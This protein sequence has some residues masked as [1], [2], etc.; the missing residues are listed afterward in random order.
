MSNNRIPF[1]RS[2]RLGLDI[3]RHIALDAGAGTGKTTVMA[4]R[5]VQHLISPLQRSTLVLPN[6]P[7]EP[8]SGHGSLR[9]PARERTERKAWQGLLPSEVVAITFTRKAASEL[10]ARIRARVAATRKSPVKAGDDEGIFD[11]RISSDADVEMLLS[12]LDEAP[13]STIDAFLSQLLAPHLDLVAVHPSREQ[14]AQERAPLLIEEALHSAWRIRTVNDAQEAGV[15]GYVNSFIEA[16]N[17]LA[18]A[19][20]GQE[21]AS[22]VLSG[23]LNK[24]LFVEESKRAIEAHSLRLGAPFGHDTQIPEQLFLEMF[25]QPIAEEIDSFAVE[26][27]ALLNDYIDL[28]LPH[29]ASYIDPAQVAAG[30]PETRFN[31]LRHMARH[32][33]E[34]EPLLRMQ[35]VWNT[36]IA[37]GGKIKTDG[38]KTTFFPKGA[39][40]PTSTSG[41]HPG[42]LP[43]SKAKGVTGAQKDA[44]N[45]SAKALGQTMSNMLNSQTG[46]LICLMGRSATL[47][48]PAIE[49]PYIPE[50]ST[51]SLAELGV[52]LPETMGDVGNMR[53]GAALQSQILL[54][55]LRVHEACKDIL[56]QLK[57]HEGVHDFDDIQNLA[58]DLLLARCPDMVRFDYPVAVVEALD[59]LGNE[60]WS[61]HHISRALTLAG[62]DEAC[63]LDLQRRHHVL[64][65]IRRQYRAFIIDEYQDTN[66]AHFRLL[67]RLW[68]HRSLHHGEPERPLGPWD[69]TVCIVGDMKQSIYRF[70]QAE[71]SVMRRAVAAIMAANENELYESRWP[72]EVRREG[73]GRD[74]RPLG[75]GGETSAFITADALAPGEVVSQAWTHVS[76]GTDT[77][78][79]APEFSGGDRQMFR[80]HGLIDLTSNYRT[81]PNLVHAMNGI[82]RDVFHPRH[83]L[84]PGEWHA[85]AQ[86]L[87]AG[88]LS[89]DTPGVLEWLM[90]L[91]TEEGE[92]S[93]DLSVPVDVFSNQKSK[94]IHLEHELIAGRLSALLQGQ[95]TQVWSAADRAFRDVEGQDAAVDPSD[96]MILV[97]SRK[98]VPDLIR[99][100][101]Q[102]GIPVVA[103]R[104]GSLLGRP[105]VQPLMAL[106]NLIANP[107]SRAA[108]LGIARSPVLGFTDG[109]IQS[110]MEQAPESDWWS[111]LEHHAPN[112][113]IATLVAHLGRL[114]RKGALY[115]VVDAVLDHSDLL[116]AFPEDT[117]RQNAEAWYSLAASI[118]NELGHEAA[119]IHER[120]CELQRLGQKGPSATNVPAGGAVRIMT[121]HNAKGLEAD[122]VFVAGLFK[123]GASDTQL[124]T[125]ENVLV[126]PQII[127]GRINPWRSLTR[128]QDGLWEFTLQLDQAQTQAERRR[129]FYVALTRARDRL[130]LVGAHKNTST[131]NAASGELEVESKASRKTMGGMWIEGLRSLAHEGQIADSPWL[132][133]GD[134][135]HQI[136]PPYDKTTLTLDPFALSQN[137]KLG[138]EAIQSIRIYHHPD[139]FE[140]GQKSTPLE[141]WRLLEQRIEDLP[142]ESQPQTPPL[143]VMESVRMTAHGLDTSNLC[144][145]RHWLSEVKGWVPEKLNLIGVKKESK[146]T[147]S[148]Y[149]PA[150]VFGTMM[151][152]LVEL[153]LANPSLRAAPHSIPLPAAWQ[154]EG[155]DGLDDEA[156]ID[157]VLAEEGYI[158]QGKDASSHVAKRAGERLVELGSLVREGLLG[159]LAAGETH[160]GLTVEGLRTELPFY[161]SHSVDVEG[162]KRTMFD[163]AEPI[164]HATIEALTLIFD[165][166]ADLVLALR[167]DSNQGF[168]QI[169]DLKTKGCRNGFNATNISKGTA[170]QQYKGDV[171]NPEP[172]TDAERALLEEHR[173]QL[174][175]YSMALEAIEMSK[176][177]EEQ[178]TILPPAL[179]VGASGRM[180][181]LSP[182]AFVKARKDLDDQLEWIGH[183]A[184]V[185]ETLDE[186]ERLGPETSEPCLTCPFYTGDV[187]LCGPAGSSLGL[188]PF[189][190]E[191]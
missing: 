51:Y 150:T 113:N 10:K 112:K 161:H 35:W 119:A 13:I 122:V 44:I 17:R 160:F 106:L 164:N 3:D 12:S 36:A 95:T 172:S 99:R 81:K 141:D 165:G 53:V 26:L 63:A 1:N 98:H 58:A 48:S 47:L 131:I 142:V 74:P 187:R 84:L 64:Q 147:S 24:S 177:A 169:V 118:G 130:I 72:P 89:D 126:T 60:P 69:P 70:R 14:I 59:G 4:E 34:Q 176:P 92:V 190:A 100:L 124:N 181:Q 138:G 83:H 46:R 68:G 111:H 55:L 167:N 175:L 41:W 184:V 170:L 110:M 109:Q 73:F 43:K 22:V 76:L 29:A 101:Q 137:A 183:L 28:Y 62:D 166:R 8:L 82:F 157:V 151:H 140:A 94:D 57:A 188:G 139:C 86:D 186:P 79:Y 56:A 145:R 16:R 54:D 155:K 132:L 115:E 174:T 39:L 134:L 153:G 144:H 61:D 96:V 65:T 91:S 19:L 159:K 114:V 77:G 80:Q 179:L 90:P 18:V 67:A 152:R 116:V 88:R 191:V 148:Q 149:P 30:G 182:G 123:A 162:L 2:Q 71:V 85:T 178:R 171:L 125:K 107:G 108:V 15:L 5:Y 38:T 168:L 104:Q 93:S 50:G 31:H 133:T 7:R 87:D 11:P 128:P 135:S 25:L 185:P 158:R 23:M 78:D 20:G 27:H 105:I 103:D 37:A 75:A 146:G 156:M 52:Q 117:D 173:L 9:A 97:H 143:M 136:L 6:G 66:P 163:V 21:Q 154:F 127:A 102:R 40:P 32:A 49:S 120:M 189:D 129:S 121:V 180:I 33:F 45:A 42:L